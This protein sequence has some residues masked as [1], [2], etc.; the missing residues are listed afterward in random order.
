MEDGSQVLI[1]A[2]AVSHGGLEVTSPEEAERGEASDKITI[3]DLLDVSL[4]LGNDFS[5]KLF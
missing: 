4:S 1:H 5:G 2:L 3:E